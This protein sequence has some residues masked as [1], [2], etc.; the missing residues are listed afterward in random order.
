MATNTVFTTLSSRPI[1]ALCRTRM[2]GLPLIERGTNT[3][4]EDL[5][6]TNKLEQGNVI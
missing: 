2:T 5:M 1:L 3:S 6:A 4:D